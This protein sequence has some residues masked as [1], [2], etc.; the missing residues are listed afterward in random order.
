MLVLYSAILLV[1]LLHHEPWRDEMQ[2]W[3]LAR[4]SGTLVDLWRNTRYEGHPLFWHLLLWVLSRWSTSPLAMQLLH[5]AVAILSAGIFLARAP[6]PRWVRGLWIFGYFPLYEYGVISRNYGLT[7]LFLWLALAW[8]GKPLRLA[9]ALGLAAHASPMGVLLVPALAGVLLSGEKHTRALLFPVAVSWLLAV[10]TCLPPADYEHARGLFF[11]WDSL[12][13][14]YV[15]RGLLTAFFPVFRP[16]LHFWNN[17]ALFP[18]SPPQVGLAL[19]LATAFLTAF[20]ALA[21][22][23]V[24]RDL[25]TLACYL[26][27][28]ATLAAFFY[29]KFPG[30]VRHHGF[31]LIWSVA[32]LWLAAETEQVGK[33]WRTAFFA[34]TTL[35]ALVGAVTAARVDLVKPFSSAAMAAR[36]VLRACDS[37]FIVGHPD[38]AASTV[39]AYLPPGTVYYPTTQAP[40]SFIVWNLARSQRE[41]LPEE[42][43]VA[44]ASRFHACL[45]LNRPLVAPGPCS[46]RAALPPAVVMDEQFWLYRCGSSS[47]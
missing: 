18:F 38:W 34:T 26:T 40:G 41:Q 27:G 7:V 30:A 36:E 6:F 24:G 32:C 35:A 28:L 33:P 15:L 16:E 10:V 14:Y 25:R 2:A 47:Q 5:A 29:V 17:P 39:A 11:R 23:A 1:L 19:F 37:G 9:L 3:L 44:T 31:V 13:A 43:L 21:V 46:L 45:L 42:E 22:L 4:D 12:R 20:V 8:R